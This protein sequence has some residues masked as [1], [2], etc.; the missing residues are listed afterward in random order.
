MNEQ[1]LR[2]WLNQPNQNLLEEIENIVPVRFTLWDKEYH[3]CQIHKSENDN[4]CPVEVE[5]Y[6]RNETSQAKI[7]HEMLHAKTG[8]ILG[9]GISLFDV[10][11]KTLAYEGLLQIKNAEKIVTA[12]EHVIFF[13]DYLDMGY[14]EEDSFEENELSEESRNLLTFLCE[15]GLKL[16]GKYD[17]D[18]VFQY[19]SLGFTLYFY[20]N[21]E[22]FQEEV[23]ML[24]QMDRGLFS[25][26]RIL[27][28]ACTD[29][30][31]M[32]ENKEYLSEAYKRF[33]TE[34]N[35]WFRVNRTG[36]R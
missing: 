10:S 36:R 13:P 4:Y 23:G 6:Y 34:I 7:A 29:L 14:R 25:K 26:L 11:N 2:V 33:G 35:H 15:H 20:P 24:N 16:G 19:L 1:E 30:E 17:V 5:I 8:L 28:D 3:G 21:T 9:D 18:R 31:V 27:R 12:C 22:R 32:P